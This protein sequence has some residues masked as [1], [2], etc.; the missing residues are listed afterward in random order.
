MKAIR[1]LSQ[2]WNLHS[3]A[4]I[5]HP[6]WNR[7]FREEGSIRLPEAY[8]AT[9]LPPVTEK[10]NGTQNKQALV[11]TRKKLERTLGR[12]RGSSSQRPALAKVVNIAGKKG[13]RP[14]RG[15]KTYECRCF[16]ENNSF[17]DIWLIRTSYTAGVRLG[18]RNGTAGPLHCPGAHAHTKE[19]NSRSLFLSLRSQQHLS[20]RIV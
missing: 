14:R 9:L 12:H 17:K 15:Y 5:R 6:T 8:K 18:E 13:H 19:P 2:G 7:Q 20:G 3:T 16:T 4:Q 1:S 11:Q 10:V